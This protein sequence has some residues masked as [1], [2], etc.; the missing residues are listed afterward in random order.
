[1]KT[2]VALDAD[3][4]LVHTGSTAANEADVKQDADPFQGKDQLANSL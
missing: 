2:Y 1:M 3:Y 4:D